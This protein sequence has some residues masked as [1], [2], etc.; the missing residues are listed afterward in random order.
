MKN[1]TVRDRLA[2]LEHQVDNLRRQLLEIRELA[3]GD[4]PLF[5]TTRDGE[6]TRL[7]EA[8]RI[9][10][11]NEDTRGKQVTTLQAEI[12]RLRIQQIRPAVPGE[13][14]EA[15]RALARGL[16]VTADHNPEQEARARAERLIVYLDKV[17]DWVGVPR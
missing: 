14:A 15:F 5:T 11:S 10:R 12:N 4:M 3:E 9:S 8:L 2:G 17:R 7:Q 6:I 13:V 1:E 16:E